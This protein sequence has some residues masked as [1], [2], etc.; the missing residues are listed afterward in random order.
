METEGPQMT[1]QH[2]AYVLRAGLARLH[3]HA[4]KHAHT[5]Q[6]VTLTAFPQQQWLRERASMLRY[7]HVHCVTCSSTRHKTRNSFRGSGSEDSEL[8]WTKRSARIRKRLATG[9]KYSAV[10][11]DASMKQ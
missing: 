9:K 4:R 5:G 8:N 3:M 2:D 6:Y 7:T 1:S 10:A 11:F